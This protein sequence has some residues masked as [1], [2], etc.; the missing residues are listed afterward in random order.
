M[1]VLGEKGAVGAVRVLTLN[2]WGRNGAWGERRRVLAD[3]L[4]ELAP[5]VV[6]FQEAVAKDGYDQVADLLGAG[7]H[8]VHHGGRPEAGTGLSIASRWDFGEVWGET[9]HVT[10][11]AG[12]SEVAVAEVLA[13]DALGRTLLFAHHNASWQ[14]GFERER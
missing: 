9:L 10:P 1:R 6:A 11:R 5:D 2:L 12:P 3:G 7:Y 8:V 13:P 14:Q 4:R